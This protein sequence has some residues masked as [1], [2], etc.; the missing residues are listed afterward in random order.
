[1]AGSKMLL[2]E[3]NDDYHVVLNLQGS[4]RIRVL[5]K[6]QIHDLKGVEALLESLPVRIKASTGGA[7]GAIVDADTDLAGRWHGIRNNLRQLGYTEVPDDPLPQGTIVQPPPDTLRPKVGIWLMP[8]NSTSGILEDFLRFLVPSDDPLI[9]AAEQAIDNL[10]VT[11]F[12][13]KDRSKA[14]M[15]TWLA[16]REE[17]GK[18]FGQAITAHYL[19][20]GVPQADVFVKW[21]QT[22]F[23]D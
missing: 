23:A 18:P 22:L 7:V 10:P 15:H 1:M 8:D 11:P 2:V 6:A 4:R 20:A 21:L 16:W 19:D 12:P 14:L 13:E 9:A 17:P 5:D 3:G